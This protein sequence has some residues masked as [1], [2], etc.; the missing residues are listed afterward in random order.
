MESLK[1]LYLMILETICKHYGAGNPTILVN[2]LN[3]F[4]PS[5]KQYLLTKIFLR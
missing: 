4:I 2:I 5:L 1:R 3:I